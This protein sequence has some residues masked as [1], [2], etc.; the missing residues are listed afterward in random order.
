MPQVQRQGQPT[1]GGRG[2]GGGGAPGDDA[3]GG[4]GFGVGG[5]NAAGP[6]PRVVLRFAT[7]E[8]NLLISG[9]LAGGSELVG[10]AAVVDVPVG[11]GHVVMFAN[12]PMCRHQTQRQFLPG[13]QC[14]LEL[15]QSGSGTS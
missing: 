4:A 9:E 11:Q 10:K 8:R 6:R 14:C 3:G 7:D 13:F 15:Q 1:Q 5:G 2:G 12:N